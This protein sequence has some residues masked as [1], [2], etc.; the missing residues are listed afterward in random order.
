MTLHL[1]L[2]VHFIHGSKMIFFK[3]SGHIMPHFLIGL[4]G[5]KT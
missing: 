1:T 4:T 2:P 5:L 3:G